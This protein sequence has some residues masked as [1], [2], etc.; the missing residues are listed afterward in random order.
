M[1]KVVTASIFLLAA[2]FYV[3]P[4]MAEGVPASPYYPAFHPEKA[5]QEE[6]FS[7]AD[8]KD[9]DTGETLIR[10]RKMIKGKKGAHVMSAILVAGSVEKI[11]AVVMDCKGQ[12]EYIP[13][14]VGCS[15]TYAPGVSE[16]AVVKYEQTE[17]LKFGFGFISKEVE[18]T[19]HVFA[20]R[21][22]VRGWT[23]KSGDIEAT[24]GYWRVVPY[25]KDHQ[26]LVYDVYTNPGTVIPGW[27]QD[28][29]IKQDLPNTLVAFKKRVEKIAD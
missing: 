8:L 11:F 15:N 26:I 7:E 4:A 23:L 24:E 21:P 9:L 22:Y 29:L 5:L 17:K 14:L 18:Y 19:L 12:P 13:H 16:A 6:K 20:V 3:A 1:T 10:S 25:K 2:L 28:I 27:V